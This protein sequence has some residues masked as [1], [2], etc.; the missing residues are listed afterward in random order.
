MQ[1]WEYANVLIRNNKVDQVPI[2][3]SANITL[4]MSADN[5]LTEFGNSGWELIGTASSTE[6][7]YRLFFKRPKQH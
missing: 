3:D 2:V 4:G 7:Y 1:L 6:S 5:C